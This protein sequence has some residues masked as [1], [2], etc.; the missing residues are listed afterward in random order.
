MEC[1]EMDQFDAISFKAATREHWDRCAQGWDANSNRLRRWLREATDAM[2]E[3]AEVKTGAR[4]LDV[5]AGAGDQTLDIAERVGTSGTVLA[6]DLSAGVLRLA[7]KKLRSAGYSNVEFSVQDGEC[8]TVAD[9]SF[10]AAICRLGLMF[11]PNPAKGLSE[12]RRALKPGGRSC[13]MVFS[14]PD[15]NPTI[16]IILSTA[17]KYAGQ[18]MPNPYQPGDLFSLGRP[19]L[20]DELYSRAGFRDVTTTKVMAPF[21]LPSVQDYLDFVRTSASPV[22]QILSRLGEAQQA[23]AWAEIGERLAQFNTSTGW[24]GPNELLLTTARG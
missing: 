11:L 5:A 4:V 17:L 18:R 23:A 21:I 22:L 19:G 3:M 16:S 24:A 6:T 7:E 10:D 9:R 12:M 15:K 20:I 1:N 13:A 8:L 2:L 14:A